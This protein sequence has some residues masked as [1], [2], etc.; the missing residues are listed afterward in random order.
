MAS[1]LEEPSAKRAKQDSSMDDSSVDAS[2]ISARRFALAQCPPE[3]SKGY[4]TCYAF[5]IVSCF[6]DFS[7]LDQPFSG[8]STFLFI[9]IF[10]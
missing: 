1:A 9:L 2:S 8:V 4:S 10:I 3:W 5:F 6:S 7:R